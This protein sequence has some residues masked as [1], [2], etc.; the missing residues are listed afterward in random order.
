MQ[1]FVLFKEI[2]DQTGANGVVGVF[3]ERWKAERYEFDYIKDRRC[4][5]REYAVDALDNGV[6]PLTTTMCDPE[7]AQMFPSGIIARSSEDG[8][9]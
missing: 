1:A 8:K 9:P 7:I 2:N 5:I 3:S 6:P 4:F